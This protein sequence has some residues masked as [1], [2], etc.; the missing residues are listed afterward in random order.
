MSVSDFESQVQSHLQ[1][2][3]LMQAFYS[4]CYFLDMLPRQHLCCHQ[5]LPIN[6]IK[7]AIKVA[8]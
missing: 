3:E 8:S 2:L 6:T 1:P 4:N 7:A 5:L